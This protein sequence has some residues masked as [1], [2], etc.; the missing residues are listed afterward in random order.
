MRDCLLRFLRRS[1]RGLAAESAALA[2]F[3]GM[4]LDEIPVDLESKAGLVG[5]RE[6]AV[7][8]MR[9]LGEEPVMQRVGLAAAMRLDAERAARRRQHK[10]TMDFRRGVRREDRAV[11]LGQGGDAQRLGEA[12][13]GLRRTGRT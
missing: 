8:Q 2:A 10:M 9:M 11:L 4:L 7:M 13:G 1:E 6:V 3:R 12:A 5:D